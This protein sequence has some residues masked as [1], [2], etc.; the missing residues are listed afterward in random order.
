M[1]QARDEIAHCS[2]FLDHVLVNETFETTVAEVRAV[3]H[4]ARTARARLA[5]LAAFVAG[6]R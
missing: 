1:A 4:A 2:E 5:G 6:R 3:L